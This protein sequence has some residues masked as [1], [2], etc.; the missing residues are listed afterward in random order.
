MG[1]TETP[2]NTFVFDVNIVDY[3]PPQRKIN[4]NKT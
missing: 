4:A 3:L 1:F 2:E